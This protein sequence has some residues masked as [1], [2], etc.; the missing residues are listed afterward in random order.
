[1][2]E[3]R[4]DMSTLDKIKSEIVTE[5]MEKLKMWIEMEEYEFIVKILDSYED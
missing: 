1:M 4:D 3:E 5:A 2:T